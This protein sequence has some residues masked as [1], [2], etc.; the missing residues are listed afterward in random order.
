MRKSIIVGAVALAMAANTLA[1]VAFAQPR[2]PGPP[3]GPSHDQ[4][5]KPPPRDRDGGRRPPPPGW[6]QQ[7]WEYRQR[8]ERRHRHRDN[9]D[10]DALIAGIIG[11]ALGAAIV[12]SQEEHEAVKPRLNDPDWIAWCARKY[13]SFD[14]RSGTYLGYDGLRHYCRYNSGGGY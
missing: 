12:A 4:P 11:F 14:P 8:Y 10:S 1:P 3:P 13:R 9:D 6:G 7:Q 2:P 5:H